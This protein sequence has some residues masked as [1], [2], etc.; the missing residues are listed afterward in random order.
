MY[1]GREESRFIRRPVPITNDFGMHRNWWVRNA[2]L[3][4]NP[5]S[6]YLYL[7][8]HDE[9]YEIT[10]RRVMRDLGLGRTAFTSARRILEEMGFLRTETV[11]QP[12]GSRDPEGRSIA[13]QVV[14]IDFILDDPPGPPHGPLVQAARQGT[15]FVHQLDLTAAIPANPR[16][17]ADAR[18]LTSADQTSAHP[19]AVDLH[20]ATLTAGSVPFKENQDQENQQEENQDDDDD[21]ARRDAALRAIDPRL[22]LDILTDALSRTDPGL[23]YDAAILVRASG[24]ILRRATRLVGDPAAYIAQSIAREPARWLTP[25]TSPT[26]PATGVR[27][28]NALGH[29]YV[30]EWQEICARC[31]TERAGWRD[32]RDHHH[33]Q[34]DIA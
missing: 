5:I 3:S 26:R 12:A 10:P 13:G 9:R 17:A 15:G 4:G 34:G 14:R 32:D 1:E 19:A 2:R 29:R 7:L 20:A 24:D 11:R 31:G 6:I 25:K 28:C 18:N 8:S 30:G 23:A 16:I 21:D 27:D 22:S 33:D